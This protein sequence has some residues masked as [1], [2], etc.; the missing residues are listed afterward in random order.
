MENRDLVKTSKPSRLKTFFKSAFSFGRKLDSSSAT[1][2]KTGSDIPRFVVSPPT[3]DAARGR[4]VLISARRG[5]PDSPAPAPS[6]LDASGPESHSPSRSGPP[7]SPKSAPPTPV[8][9]SETKDAEVDVAARAEVIAVLGFSRRDMVSDAVE[10]EYGDVVFAGPRVDK[11]K[12]PAVESDIEESEC[13]EDEKDGEK[14]GPVVDK[15]KGPGVELDESEE[16]SPLVTPAA[17]HSW[18]AVVSEADDEAGPSDSA[19][20][21][22]PRIVP[23]SP[24]SLPS[25]FSITLPTSE[26]GPDVPSFSTRTSSSSDSLRS[27]IIRDSSNDDSSLSQALRSLDRPKSFPDLSIQSPS[28]PEDRLLGAWGRAIANL[29]RRQSAASVEGWLVPEAS[30]EGVVPTTS[31]ENLKGIFVP[32]S[33]EN[34][35]GEV[36]APNM[37]IADIETAGGS[38]SL[39]TPQIAQS[40]T[41]PR[42]VVNPDRRAANSSD[43][44][45]IPLAF[46]AARASARN[47]IATSGKASTI[48]TDDAASFGTVGLS[49]SSGA[50]DSAVFVATVSRRGSSP[51]LATRIHDEDNHG[52]LAGRGES[53][54]SI[55]EKKDLAADDD[56]D[57]STIVPASSRPSAATARPSIASSVHITATPV[58]SP[59]PGDSRPEPLPLPKPTYFI[60]PSPPSTLPTSSLRPNPAEAPV[61]R[62][63]A[64]SPEPSFAPAPA[65]VPTQQRHKKK[66]MGACMGWV[67]ALFGSPHRPTA[68]TPAPALAVS[69]LRGRSPAPNRN[70]AFALIGRLSSPIYPLSFYNPYG[71]S[72]DPLRNNLG[73]LNPIA[74][75]T[76]NHARP[77]AIPYQLPIPPPSPL[78]IP[79][80]PPPD[81]TRLA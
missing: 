6:P 31:P 30:A 1:L 12:G 54:P 10:E 3:L 47:S 18:A 77:L 51:S 60:A 28:N 69:S 33:D 58:S 9:N 24:G 22:S 48:R 59:P 23:D 11:G 19:S 32:V 25:S 45:D 46:A 56:A 7:A 13:E 81:I 43:E 74:P 76:L 39:F 72:P 40:P 49:P 26:S 55:M 38:V 75:T 67:K 66:K 4:E 64:R 73:F 15:G 50:D 65:P 17:G 57:L 29:E 78:H 80:P 34:A 62:S 27:F 61:P 42:D 53:S 14:W 8:M 35:S 70:L 36:E 71:S 2:S 5:A 52:V 41:P 37:A 21:H 16:A 20:S 68:P 79:D 63:V 44:D